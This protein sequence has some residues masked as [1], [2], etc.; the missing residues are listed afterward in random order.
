MV[1]GL[2]RRNRFRALGENGLGWKG[3]KRARGSIAKSGKRK[4][5][6]RGMPERAGCKKGMFLKKEEQG[7]MGGFPTSN[8]PRETRSVRILP[9]EV[10]RNPSGGNGEGEITKKER[11]FLEGV[12][13]NKRRDRPRGIEK[14]A[15][16]G[17]S[18]IKKE[19]HRKK[20]R[21]SSITRAEKRQSPRRVVIA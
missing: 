1:E 16:G 21:G 3:L 8:D 5:I 7:T 2:R 9:R 6:E 13:T 14:N 18:Q 15:A 19:P 11:I 20:K 10:E 17:T 4:E 12:L